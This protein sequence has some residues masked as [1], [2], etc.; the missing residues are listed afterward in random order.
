[1]RVVIVYESLFG[2]T[3]EIAEAIRDGIREAQPD[4]RVA[5]VRATEA[6]RDAALGADLLVVG[7]PT[8]AHSLSSAIT[9][10]MGLRAEERAPANVPGH[11][12]EQGAAGPGLREWF[13]GLPK[14]AAGS[15]CAAFDTRGDVRLA[16]GAANTIARRLRHHG[17]QLVAEPTGFI[18]EDVEGP[19]R[20]GEQ[21]R[22]RAWGAGLLR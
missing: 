1:M 13:H 9:R 16:G 12:V 6:D 22:A 14:A 10:K 15:L 4:S 11:G 5:C 3:H 19:L 21:E 17:Y 7:G 8:H 18:V 20:D 2:N